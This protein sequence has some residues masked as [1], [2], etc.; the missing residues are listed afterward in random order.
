MILSH[1]H[2]NINFAYFQPRLSMMLYFFILQLDKERG[3]ERVLNL[4]GHKSPV[5]CVDW[6]TSVHYKLC[7]TASVDG[8]VRL[9]TLLT[10]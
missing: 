3:L 7:L 6:S 4:E 8:R 2:L 1:V 10:K 5:I 9:S